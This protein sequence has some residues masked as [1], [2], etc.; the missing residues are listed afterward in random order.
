MIC[1]SSASPGT[2]IIFFKVDKIFEF[3]GKKMIQSKI[4]EANFISVMTRFVIDLVADSI[5][6]TYDFLGLT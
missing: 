5:R 2:L 6:L 4:F 3:G 1:Y